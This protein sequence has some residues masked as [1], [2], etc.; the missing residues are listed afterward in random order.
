MHPAI[1]AVQPATDL[2]VL[3]GVAFW[4][5]ITL[6]ASAF[7]VR[8]PRGTLVFCC[9]S[10]NRGSRHLRR[11]SR[12]WLGCGP[13]DHGTAGAQGPGP[14][15][16]NP[17][18]PR[19]R[20]PSRHARS[21]RLRRH[22]LNLPRPGGHIRRDDHRR[23][24][25]LPTECLDYRHRR[26]PDARARLQGWCCLATL[27]ATGRTCSRSD[28]WRGLWPR[29]TRDCRVG[30]VSG[31]RVLFALPLYTTRVAHHRFVEMRE[32]FTQT[33][34]ALAEAVDKRDP[35]TS[36]HSRRVMMIASDIGQV[37]RCNAAEME[38][39]EWGGA[40]PR[41]REDRCPRPRPAQS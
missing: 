13:W 21:V 34:G 14:L 11:A 15:V 9:D 24:D 33:I 3:L 2:T 38:A 7:P 12:G 8:M 10:A 29:P 31:Q 25:P 41:C 17:V 23:V 28:H 4:T 18:Q 40:A 16:R 27:K 22:H 32:M 26:E 30:P 39:L 5:V 1:A 19:G 35:T 36:M 20:S 6:F 37:M